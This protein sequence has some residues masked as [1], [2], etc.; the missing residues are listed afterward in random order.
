VPASTEEPSRKIS[1]G[2][3]ARRPI[4]SGR[5]KPEADRVDPRLDSKSTA[6]EVLRL[7]AYAR[8][9]KVSGWKNTEQARVTS[10]KTGGI[11]VLNGN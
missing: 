8:R 10:Q 5:G 2:T 9:L 4:F 1:V 11:L 3:D 6:E 7:G